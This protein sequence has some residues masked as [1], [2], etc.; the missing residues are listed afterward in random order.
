MHF[1]VLFGVI[2]K[3]AF[4]SSNCDVGTLDL[5]VFDVTKASID[6]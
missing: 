1:I 3:L 2:A 5:S 6:V 4:V